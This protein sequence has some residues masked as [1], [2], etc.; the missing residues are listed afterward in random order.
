MKRLLTTA[1]LGLIL[2]VA[3]PLSGLAPVAPARA[4]QMLRIAAVVNEDIISM[5]DLLE[6]IDLQLFSTGQQAN[7]TVRR[8]LAPQILRQIIEEK[9]MMQEWRRR[10]VSV[11]D[12]DIAPQIDAIEQSIRMPK[13]ALLKSLETQG[14]ATQAFTDQLRARAGWER[15]MAQKVRATR[16]VTEEEVDQQLAELRAT[17]GKPEYRLSDIFLSFDSAGGEPQ[18]K[19]IADTIL[20]E[21]GKGATFTQVARQFS[22]AAAASTGGDLGWVRQGQLEPE[23]ERAAAS[24]VQGQ[25]SAPIKT[26]VGY[27]IL[28]LRDKR[29]SA[30]AD[31]TKSTLTLS[32]VLLPVPANA[33][34][35]D[36]EGQVALANEI[37]AASD[38]CQT[39]NDLVK[40]LGGGPIGVGTLAQLPEQYATAVASVGKGKT[41]PAT[42][43]TE[44]V[45]LF[46]VCDRSDDGAG[47]PSRNDV[48]AD[49]FVQRIEA[50]SRRSI[51]DLRQTAN[52]EV[53]L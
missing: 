48:R 40:P 39:F 22:N 21:L 7:D 31:P 43:T 33:S 9:L 37:A 25:V 20:T 16:S 11:S 41:S 50:E 12:A 10:G 2:S 19:Q 51:R 18:A 28:Y 29:L 38:S 42:R 13:G 23:L 47:L 36:W 5:Y 46:Y 34:A 4:Q 1:A 6:R 17:Q 14:I 35:R 44:G 27:H 24:L 26:L 49:L 53:R 30:T 3:S 15:L 45:N 52:I 8:Q 32:R